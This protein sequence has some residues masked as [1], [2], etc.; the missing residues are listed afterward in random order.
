MHS[1]PTS[2]KRLP[3]KTK[4]FF[5][6]AF[7]YRQKA[8][9]FGYNAP[10]KPTYTADNVP[11]DPEKWAEWSLDISEKETLLFLDRAYEEITPGSYITVKR[12][13]KA[14]TIRVREVDTNPRTAYGISSKST[15]LTLD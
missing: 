7:V 5:P 13:N 8:A 14:K 4:P 11:D 12:G 6:Q 2:K 15:L 3:R 1:R 9:V 10:K